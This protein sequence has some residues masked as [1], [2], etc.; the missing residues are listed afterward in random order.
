ML[1]SGKVQSGPGRE[2]RGLQCEENVAIVLPT[3]IRVWERSSRQ[4]ARN[5]LRAALVTFLTGKAPDKT[6]LREGEVCLTERPAWEGSLHLGAGY[7]A[8]SSHLTAQK[9][10]PKE[11]LALGSSLL[12][13]SEMKGLW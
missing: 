6:E 7:K 8:L 11:C 13:F 4:T 3:Q 10:E 1:W 12:S 9:G 5:H 2:E